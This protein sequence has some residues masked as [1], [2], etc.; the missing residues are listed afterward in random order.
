[1]RADVDHAVDRGANLE[2]DQ[3]SAVEGKAIAVIA[4]GAPTIAATIRVIAG[5]TIAI[6]TVIVTAV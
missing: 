3:T 2:A 5:I 6:V 1:M 4:T